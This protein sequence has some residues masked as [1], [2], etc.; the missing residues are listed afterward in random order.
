M[1]QASAVPGSRPSWSVAPPA[2]TIRTLSEEEAETSVPRLV[3]WSAVQEAS[4]IP[5][6]KHRASALGE[7]I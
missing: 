7:Y 3:T 6:S 1:A 2:A 4:A 5:S